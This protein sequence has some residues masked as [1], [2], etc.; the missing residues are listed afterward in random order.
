MSNKEEMQRQLGMNPSTASGALKK[1][2]MFSMAQRLGEDICHQCG[3]KIETVKEF[4]IEHIVP[5]LHS[6]DPK[7]TFFSL[8]NIAFSHFLCNVKAGRRA[9]LHSTEEE[10]KKAKRDSEKRNRVYCPI[11]RK[12]QYLRTGT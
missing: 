7:T 12:A 8:E 6:E 11:K 2:I 3:N 5:W 1:E 10:R 4:S 9:V